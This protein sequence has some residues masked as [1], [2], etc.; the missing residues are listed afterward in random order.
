MILSHRI[1][2]DT[3]HSCA[4]PETQPDQESGNDSDCASISLPDDAGGDP[5]PVSPAG[6]IRL[7]SEQLVQMVEAL[8]IEYT[9]PEP[10]GVDPIMNVLY[11]SF[12]E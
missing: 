5:M 8:E 9:P 10:R 11:S 1:T 4:D 12:L 2:Q 3:V 7:Y 6:D